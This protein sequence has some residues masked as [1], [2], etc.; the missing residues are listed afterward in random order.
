MYKKNFK[1]FA[2]FANA[3]RKVVVGILFFGSLTAGCLGVSALAGAKLAGGAPVFEG[4]AL[5]AIAF[6]FLIAI[7][8]GIAYNMVCEEDI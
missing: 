6:G 5:M 3:V 2:Q 1:K 4:Y 7:P 8:F